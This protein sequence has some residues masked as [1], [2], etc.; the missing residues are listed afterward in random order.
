MTYNRRKA[1][2]TINLCRTML[3]DIEDL[4]YDVSNCLVDTDFWGFQTN[5]ERMGVIV[6]LLRRT[7][8]ELREM[9]SERLTEAI[10]MS[11]ERG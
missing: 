6:E 7:A 8:L 3:A 9:E 1:D 5:V 11:K 4:S 10:A 2:K